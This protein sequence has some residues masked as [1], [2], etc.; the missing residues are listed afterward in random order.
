MYQDEFE[1]CNPLG[2]GKGKHKILA[3]YFTLGNLHVSNR[4][5]VDSL[6]LVLLCKAK[7]VSKDNLHSLFHPLFQDIKTIETEG[8]DLGFDDCIRGTVTCITGD[9]LGSHLIGGFTTNFS[10][11]D[12]FCRYCPMLR[13]QFMQDPLIEVSLRSTCNYDSD[14]HIL[15]SSGCEHVNGIKFASPF[16]SF[17]YFH[18]CKPGMPPC[19]AHDWFEGVI[20]YDLVIIIQKFVSKKWFTLKYFNHIIRSFSYSHKDRISK[21][22]VVRNWNKLNGNACQIWCLLRLL[23]FLIGDQIQ[24]YSDPRWCIILKLHQIV[25]IIC[26]PALNAVD[27][28]C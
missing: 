26:S 6:Q 21:P 10:S 18:V 1:V 28:S 3:V 2:Q 8:I 27:I 16:N 7:F 5:K 12:F 22:L 24:D 11:G 17:N 13:T 4:S 15:E 20:A 9:N 19:I 25:G 23:P 14:I